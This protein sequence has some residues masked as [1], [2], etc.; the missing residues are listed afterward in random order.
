M[1]INMKHVD[2]NADVVV[3]VCFGQ[4]EMQSDTF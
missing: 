2:V 3:I 4:N 1:H